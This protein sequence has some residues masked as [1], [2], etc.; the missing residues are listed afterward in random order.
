MEAGRFHEALFHRINVFNIH[1]PPLKERMDDLGL[2]V[3][4][5]LTRLAGSRHGYTIT[6]TA[7]NCLQNYRWPGNIRE[8]RNVIERSI[9]LSE[10]GVITEHALPQELLGEPG[11]AKSILSLES[12]ES[13]HIKMVLRQLQRQPVSGCGKIG[14]KPQDVVPEDQRV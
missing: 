7:M 14:D 4:Y 2:L 10:N 12:M 13:Q 1:I 5:F 8:L 9:I 3:D 6:D 11:E